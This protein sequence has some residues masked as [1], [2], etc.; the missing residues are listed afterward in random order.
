VTTD[1]VSFTGDTPAATAPRER[2]AAARR[3]RGSP[4][5]RVPLARALYRACLDVGAAIARSGVSADALT[6][7]SLAVAALAGAA[8]AAGWF[9][10]AAG[11]VVLSGAFDLFDGI[12]ARASGRSSRWGALLDSTV[13]R[14]SDALP[15]LGLVVFYARGPVA[16]VPG[17]ALLGS[18]GVS[19]V[20]A[21]AEALGAVLPPLFM[22]RPERV[23]LLTLSLAAGLLSCERT[24]IPA[25]LTLFGLAVLSL[26]TLL[27]VV[28]ALRAARAS[29]S[30]HEHRD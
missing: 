7:T 14:A 29:L 4:W 12:V 11:L 20:R 5:E 17:V 25:P 9:A 27:G 19:Y 26:S 15:L 10:A 24:E 13:D 1:R 3:L 23:L 16:V 22:R 2:D 6:Y 21:R 30:S 28:V 8:A 18:F